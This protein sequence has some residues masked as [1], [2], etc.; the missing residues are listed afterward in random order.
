M[1]VA[2]FGGTSVANADAISR[3][4]EIVR[5]RANGSAAPGREPAGDHVVVVVSAF[6]GVTDELLSAGRL[7]AGGNLKAAVDKA[8]L[9][10]K[11]TLAIAAELLGTQAAPAQSW[12]VQSRKGPVRN[13]H[14]AVWDVEAQL[15]KLEELLRGTDALREFSA[16]T[17]DAVLAT[18]ELI[19][20]RLIAAAMESAGVRAEFVDPRK[21]LV[22]T[23]QHTR[24]WPVMSRT[25]AALKEKVVPLLEQGIVPV[26]G[27]FVGATAAGVTTTLGRGGS[28][29]SAAVIARCLGAGRVEIWTDVDGIMTCDPRICPDARTVDEVSF[30]EAAQLAWFGAKV[31]H[32]ATLIPAVEKDIPVHVLNSFNPDGPTTRITRQVCGRARSLKAVAAKRGVSVFTVSGER[33]PDPKGFLQSV[34]NAFERAGKHLELVCSAENSVSAAIATGE[35]VE[36]LRD[37]L[38]HFGRVE[39]E[40]GK[41][42]VCIVGED[43][44][45]SPDVI[46]RVFGALQGISIRMVSQGASKANIALLVDEA[47][48]TTA[49]QRLHSALF[50][51]HVGVQQLSTEETYECGRA[52]AH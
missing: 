45:S 16:R 22:T 28:D 14:P 51:D 50:S 25:E 12:T 32:P 48:V 35:G 36:E 7:A 17:C 37:A 52:S 41:A 47:Q 13:H 19:S 44:F 46:A 15:A 18:G 4:I 29:F 8:A 24:A 1:I 39:Y 40:T 30:E 34:F 10:R 6:A 26:I 3:V 5:G 2:K 21:C 43:L 42:I 38:S 31:V 11:R 33:T 23:A 49:V 27:G 9:L 20:S